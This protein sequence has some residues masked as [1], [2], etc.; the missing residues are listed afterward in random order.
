LQIIGEYEFGLSEEVR[1]MLADNPYVSI[2]SLSGK[3]GRLV[4]ASKLAGIIIDK[5]LDTFVA[6]ECLSACVNVFAAGDRRLISS[7][8]VIGL[9]GSA[10]PGMAAYDRAKADQ[11]SYEFLISRG[12]DEAFVQL[13]LSTSPDN[14]WIPPHEILFAA[15]LATGYAEEE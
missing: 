13:G 14:I 1:E 5:R 11:D 6:R 8:A 10:M 12:V 9:H 3:G 4:E 2:V 7:N 15:T